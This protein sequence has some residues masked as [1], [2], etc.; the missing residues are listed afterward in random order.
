MAG[1]NSMVHFFRWLKLETRL[2]DID[3]LIKSCLQKVKVDVDKALSL[4]DEL[5]NMPLDPLMLKKHPQ[6]VDTTKKVS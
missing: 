4:M 1:M 2:V 5:I 6:I 3:V